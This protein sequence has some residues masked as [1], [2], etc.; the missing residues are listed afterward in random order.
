MLSNIS[1]IQLDVVKGDDVF[2]VNVNSNL[3]KN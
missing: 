1:K 2:F 3:F